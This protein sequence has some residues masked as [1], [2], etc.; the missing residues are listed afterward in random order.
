M[1]V[2]QTQNKRTKLL[3]DDSDDE[4]QLYAKRF[5]Y[6]KK[7]EEKVRLEEKYGAS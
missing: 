7:R 2:S 3:S 1:A 6:N 5:E 4:V